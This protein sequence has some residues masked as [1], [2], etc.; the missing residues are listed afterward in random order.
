[1]KLL[2]INGNMTQAITD[3]CANAA[4]GMAPALTIA[5]VASNM[6]FRFGRMAGIHV[7]LVIERSPLELV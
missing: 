1:M 3:A 6:V 5:T 2:V 7:C 4:R